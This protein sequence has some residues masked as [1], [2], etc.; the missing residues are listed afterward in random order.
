[1]NKFFVSKV[2]GK[3]NSHISIYKSWLFLLFFWF[4]WICFISLFIWSDFFLVVS[5]TSPS[6]NPRSFPPP[7]QWL[8][9]HQQRLCVHIVELHNLL[10]FKHN[11]HD[12][13]DVIICFFTFLCVFLI[14]FKI[15]FKIV[16]L[17]IHWSYRSSRVIGVIR[18]DLKHLSTS[19]YLYL[20]NSIQHLHA[21]QYIIYKYC[22]PPVIVVV[23]S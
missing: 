14:H 23:N 15:F 13:H 7:F 6:F 2:S 9:K 18:A 21:W 3:N 19:L 20:H 11:L 17:V 16:S 1:M 10:V 12:W 4:N 8:P 22:H 5:S